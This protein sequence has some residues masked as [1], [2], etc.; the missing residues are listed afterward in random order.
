M[1][2][3]FIFK[4]VPHDPEGYLVLGHADRITDYKH[5][6]RLVEAGDPN[7]GNGEIFKKLILMTNEGGKKSPGKSKKLAGSVLMIIEPEY[8]EW[9]SNEESYPFAFEGLGDWGV[10]VFLAPPEGFLADPPSLSESISSELEGIQFNITDIGSSWKPTK[11]KYKV[12]HKKM[13]QEIYSE[14]GVKLTKK[15]AKKKGVGEWGKDDQGE[16]QGDKGGKPK[17]GGRK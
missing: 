15:L 8:I 16:G 4:S 2:G 6:G 11:V 13:T 17:N 12:K 10:E 3:E 1:S 7:W 14:I 5:L 9:S